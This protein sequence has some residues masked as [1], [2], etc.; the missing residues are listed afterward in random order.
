MTNR[1][2]EF[3]G[4]DK[5]VLLRRGYLEFRA[6]ILDHLKVL[7]PVRDKK[8]LLV[9]S[10]LRARGDLSLPAGHTTFNVVDVPVPDTLWIPDTRRQLHPQGAVSFLFTF[11]MHMG[12]VHIEECEGEQFAQLLVGEK[13]WL[14]WPPGARPVKQANPSMVIRQTPGQTLFMPGGWWHQV[15]TSTH[16]A[17]LVGEVWPAPLSNA[18]ACSPA[19]SVAELRTLSRIHGVSLG[20]AKTK[21][22]IVALLNKVRLFFVYVGR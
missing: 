6:P 17:V 12:N 21:K 20:E 18:L 5:P 4:L 22:S 7:C 11:G 15:V 1:P 2:F 16:G 10:S 8:M 3:V 9:V 19:M 13:C 14:F